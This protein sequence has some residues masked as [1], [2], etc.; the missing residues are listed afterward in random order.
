[1]DCKENK[2]NSLIENNKINL[3]DC[4][5]IFTEKENLDSMSM[6]CEHCKNKSNFSKMY[7]FERI[8][9]YLIISLKRF[10]FTK[11]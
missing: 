2:F 5:D 3:Y 4:F 8:S 7:E 6:Y 11:M 9:D 10:K 1:M